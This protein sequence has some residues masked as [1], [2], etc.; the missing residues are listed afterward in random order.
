MKHWLSA[1][2]FLLGGLLLPLHSYAKELSAEILLTDMGN[3]VKSLPYELSFIIINPQGITPIRYRHVIINNKP[4]AQIMQMDSSRREIIQKGN[5]ISYF[6]PGF[7]S[8]TLDGSYIVDYL[9]SVVFANFTK[10]QSYYNFIQLGRTH[11]GD[12]SCQ[13]IRVIPKD[14]SRFSYILLIDE[15]TKI[16][17]RIDLLDS[18]NEILEQ[19]RVISVVFNSQALQKS[20]QV[21]ASLNMPPLLL[22][23][24]SLTKQFN[25]QINQLP[26]GFEE[27]SRSCKEIA[28]NESLETMIFSDGLFSFSINVTKAGDRQLIEKPFRKGG[29]TIYTVIKGQ[30]EVTVIG[31]LPLLTASQIA[32]NVSFKEAN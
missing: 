15:K 8:F 23:P 6:E 31:Q 19:F 2:F 20:M 24:K 11:I 9:P 22:I 10:L 21:I 7:D 32:A 1:L 14:N 17:M 13:V 4:I 3:A 25:W 27:I 5:Q 30:Y 12:I 18:K 26:L 29:L 16:P 28:T